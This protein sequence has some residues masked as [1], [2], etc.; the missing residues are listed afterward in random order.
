MPDRPRTPA[1]DLREGDEILVTEMEHHANLVPWQELARAP[2]PPCAG[3]GSP[4][5]PARPHAASTH[6]LT[7]RTKVFAFAHVSNVLGTV[8]PVRALV[9][10]ARAVGALTV[11]D[12]CQSA[13]HL[14]L[15][16]PALGVDLA[17]FSGHKMFGPTGVGVLWGRGDCWTRCRRSSRAAR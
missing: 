8:N 13:P 12:A 2:V 9:D 1:L 17:A 11:L 7:E 10:A 15:D 5:G 4:T 3:S 14:P 16:V 6:L